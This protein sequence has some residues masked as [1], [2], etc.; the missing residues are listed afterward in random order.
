MKQF[1]TVIIFTLLSIGAVV[2]QDN[3]NILSAPPT[4]NRTIEGNG[5]EVDLY[6]GSLKQGRVGLIGLRGDIVRAQA[7]VFNRRVDFFSVPDR[8]G[9][10]ALIAARTDQPI[11]VY[12]L[13]VAVELSNNT[14]ANLSIGIDITNGGFIS[15]EVTLPPDDELLALL[16]PQIEEDELAFL[17]ETTTPI[18]EVVLWGREGFIAP[19]NAAL[20]SPFGAVRTF[21]ETYLSVHTGWD[22]QAGIGRP[23]VAAAGGRIVFEGQLPLRGNYILIDHGRGVYSGYAHLS[24][25]Y[26]TQGQAVTTG[27]VLGLVGTTGRSSGAHSH[28]EFIVNNEWVDAADFIQMY[29]P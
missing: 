1:A 27:Q 5:F 17:F 16:D 25:S 15:S 10:Y 19:V 13:I 28:I 9:Y 11:R 2:A 3:A 7:T 6:F 4:P 29:I 20:T 21:N 18:T 8:D 12:E 26:V 23:M 22:F 24:V 14:T